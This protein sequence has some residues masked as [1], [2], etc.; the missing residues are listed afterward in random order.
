MF[1]AGSLPHHGEM[2]DC[3]ACDNLQQLSALTGGAVFS[4]IQK[5]KKEVKSANNP[6]ETERKQDTEEKK[7]DPDDEYDLANQRPLNFEEL[8]NSTWNLLHTM[9][10]YYP[11]SP[12]EERQTATK[13]FV[14][15]LGV[16]Y[17]C[18]HCAKDFQQEIKEIPPRMESRHE[19]SQWACEIH[20]LVNDKLGKPI[21]PCN[22][23]DERW[24]FDPSQQE[25]LYE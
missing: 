19:F 22:R 25:K 8:G 21:F 2:D 23:V 14:K 18:T 6:P 11:E 16:V 20:N 13:E 12:S 7:A 17:P 24:R 9:A 15:T 4:N 3:D 5:T 10:A 1:P